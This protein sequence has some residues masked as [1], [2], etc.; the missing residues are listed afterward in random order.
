MHRRATSKLLTL[1]LPLATLLACAWT[2]PARAAAADGQPLHMIV[3]LAPGTTA[4]LAARLMGRHF[5]RS[6]KR[7]VVVENQPAASGVPATARIVRGAKDGSVLGMV[8]S[9]HVINPVMGKAL[10]FDPLTGVAPIT[11]VGSF[12]LVLVA[13]PSLPVD[14]VQDLIA[15]ARVRPGALNYGSGGNGSLLHL[16]VELLRAEAGGLEV[17]HVPYNGTAQMTA[18]LLRNQIQFGFLSVA[19]AQPLIRSGR[20]RALGVSSRTRADCLPGVP[21]LAEQGLPRYHFASWLALVA[22]GGMAPALVARHHALARDALESQEVRDVLARQGM[23]MIGNTP[24]QAAEFLAS[25]LAW[26]AALVRQ[27]G[28]AME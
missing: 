20:L 12:P 4:D 8:A 13:V 18:D 14:G 28:A 9:N 21:T 23:T 24:A 10:P 25:E 16:A 26:H 2:A 22:P 11:V 7:A 5:S 3:P 1:V 19:V 6:L 27:S 17:Q 15:L